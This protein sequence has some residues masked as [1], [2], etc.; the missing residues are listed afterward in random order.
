MSWAGSSK[1]SAAVPFDTFIQQ[2]ILDPL[3][4]VDTAFVVPEKDQQ[5][6]RRVLRRR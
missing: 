5:P 2:R 4:M 6:V 1:S 3:G